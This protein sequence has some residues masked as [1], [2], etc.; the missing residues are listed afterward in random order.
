MRARVYAS[1]AE[2]QAAYRARKRNA[3]SPNVTLPTMRL[4]WQGDRARLYAGDARNLDAL[5]GGSVGLVVTSP[6]YWN[7]RQE[8]ASWPTYAAYLADMARAWTECYRVLCEGGRLAVNVPDGYG[9]P[10]NGGYLTLGDDTARAIQAAGFT[11]R[12]KVIWYK[13]NAVARGSTA[14]GSWLSASDPSLRDCYEVVIL[15]HKGSARRPG[16]KLVDRDTFLAATVSVW[17]VQPA[18]SKWHPAPFPAEIPRR[19]IAGWSFPGDTVL[20]PFAGTA[21]TV[22]EAA[23]AGRLGVGV[24]LCAAYLDRAV[25]DWQARQVKG[26]GGSKV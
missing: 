19:L 17:E 6:P 25:A 9:R 24:D 3:S 8:Y 26:E 23:R 12:G 2:R 15:A 22:W 13:G 20:D 4:H 11:L 1:H 10:G 5:A 21:I 16:P 7:A 18:R 14:W